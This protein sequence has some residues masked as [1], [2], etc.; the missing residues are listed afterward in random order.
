MSNKV[1]H[2][3]Y[4]K[5]PIV[6]AIIQ[7]RYEKIE[8]FDSKK[9]I[10]AGEKRKKEYPTSKIGISHTIKLD[11]TSET[12]ISLGNNEINGVVFKS[13]DQTKVLTV[14]L[15]KFTLEFHGKYPGWDSVEKEVKELWALFSPELV[16]L[17][18]LGLSMRYTN[19]INLPIETRE[20]NKYFNIYIHS[21]TGDHVISQFEIRYTS[22]PEEGL[23]VHVGHL[24]DA[25]IDGSLP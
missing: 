15:D 4:N 2:E 7:F 19:R 1:K 8:N 22:T 18:L 23:I 17:K 12:K 6:V 24:L 20:I 21:K 9:I 10:S 14:G 5:A 11:H 3:V 25:A 16:G 13:S